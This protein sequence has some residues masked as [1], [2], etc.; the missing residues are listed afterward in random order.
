MQP[1]WPGWTG[2]LQVH[3]A[4]AKPG[5]SRARVWGPRPSCYPPSASLWPPCFLSCCEQEEP[6]Y[7]AIWGDNKAFNEVIISPAMLHEHL[8]YVVMEGLN[9]VSRRPALC[10]NALLEPTVPC[11]PYLCPHIIGKGVDAQRSKPES[12]A[13]PQWGQRAHSCPGLHTPAPSASPHGPVVGRS[14]GDSQRPV[15]KAG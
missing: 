15:S 9:K 1:S 10:P 3:L 11:E 7:F 13:G 5:Q 12:P 2:G 4:P 6:T 8:P 14:L